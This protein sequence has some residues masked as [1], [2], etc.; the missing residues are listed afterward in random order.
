MPFPQENQRHREKS[1]PVRERGSKHNRWTDSFKLDHLDHPVED[2]QQFSLSETNFI[3]YIPISMSSL[4][5]QMVKR[6]PTMRE[7]W[8]Q[9]LGREDLPEKEMA[10]HSRKI[11]WT[12]KPGRLQ[13][14]G[15]QNVRHD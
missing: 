10:T 15:L 3:K 14:R 7:T 12:E 8:V 6:L 11:P 13:P 4:V 2:G 5:A 9:S 1:S